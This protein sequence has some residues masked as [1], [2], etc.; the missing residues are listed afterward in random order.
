MCAAQNPAASGPEFVLTLSCP[1][2]RGIVAGVANLL[3]GHGCNITESQQFGD[4][5][6]GRFFLRMQFAA[7]G[8]PGGVDGVGEDALRGAFAPLAAEFA[9]EW[10]LRRCDVRPRVLLMVSRFGHCLNDLLYRQRSGLLHAEIAG[11]VSNHPDL[12]YL[13]RSYDL[14]FHHLPVR[15]ETKER[16]EARLLELV[17]A[18]DIDL[19]VL[20]RYMQVLSADLCEKLPGKVINIHHSFLPGFKG[21][22]PYHQAHARGVKLIGATAHYVTADLDEGPIIEQEVARVDHGSSPEQLAAMGRDLESQALARA[23]NWHAERRV[24]LNGAKTVVFR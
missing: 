12:E 7:E 17:A 10:D 13:A 1:D 3:A 24:L 23:V 18:Q 19:V 11:V 4:H 6:T 15:P 9:M 21:A 2:T 8:G 20:A 22:R 5:Y 14:D 16:Q